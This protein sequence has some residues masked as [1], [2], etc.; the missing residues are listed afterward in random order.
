MFARSLPGGRLDRRAGLAAAALWLFFA[1]CGAQ[2]RAEVARGAGTLKPATVKLTHKLTAADTK[3]NHELGYSVAMDG[4]TILAGAP[5][6]GGGF[7]VGAAY[8]F[9][10]SGKTW[11][12]QAKLMAADAYTHA[13][14]GVDLALSGDHA[15]VLA[16]NRFDEEELYAF[17]RKGGSWSQ[18]QKLVLLKHDSWNDPTPSIAMDGDTAV[19]GMPPEAP[20]YKWDAGAAYIMVRSG[21]TWSQQAKLLSPSPGANDFLGRAVAIEGD[22][23]AVGAPGDDPSGADVGAIHVFSRS[24]T[25]WTHEQKLTPPAGTACWLGEAVALS[26]DTVLAGCPKG[27]YQG[28]WTGSAILYRRAST[29]WKFQQ[30]IG[31]ADGA[32]ARKFGASVAMRG[33]MALVGDPDNRTNALEA[34]AAYIFVRNGVTW[35]QRHK[36]VATKGQKKDSLGNAV[37]L[38]KGWAVMGARGDSEKA[39]FAGAVLLHDMAAGGKADET[40]ANLAA[41]TICRPVAGGCDV[42]ERCDGVSPACPA[43]EVLPAGGTCR[44][45]KAPCDAAEKCDGKRPKCPADAMQPAG[46]ACRAAT[47]ECNIVG[48]CLGYAPWC[49]VDSDVPDGEPCRDGAGTCQGGV[50][51]LKGSGSGGCNLGRA[52]QM[53]GGWLW[54]LLLLLAARRWGRGHGDK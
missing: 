51:E 29:T 12:Q 36:L 38:G 43:D 37:A 7:A 44:A 2:D 52:G 23:V 11:N 27:R 21:K 14:F 13:F 5:F 20:S 24:G 26:G 6:S 45:S 32:L 3:K 39:K 40:C 42:A 53:S 30:E 8:A 9:V 18:T 19:V 47:G 28:K 41:G 1:G 34:G 54:L 15:L 35:R 48:K 10:R 50:C 49:V 4:D 33:N 46:A 17:A 22:R 31:P 25:Q 16:T